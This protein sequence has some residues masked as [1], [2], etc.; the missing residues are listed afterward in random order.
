MKLPKFITDYGMQANGDGIYTPFIY[1]SLKNRSRGEKWLDKNGFKLV[2]FLL[3]EDVE[4]KD[5]RK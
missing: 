2:R 3:R 5:E 4:L 1:T